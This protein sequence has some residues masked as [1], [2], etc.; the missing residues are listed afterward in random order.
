MAK[1]KPST[2]LC[3]YCKTEI[4]YDAK[5]CPQCRKRVKGG[6]MKW[7]VIAIVVMAIIGIISGGGGKSSSSTNTVTDKTAVTQNVSI[8]QNTSTE[9]PEETKETSSPEKTGINA[10]LDS[11]KIGERNAVLSAINY[12]DF[13]AF[14]RDGLIDQLSSEYGSGYTD[15][16][17]N[18]AVD[19]LEEHSLVDWDEQAIR[20][21]QNYLDFTAFSRQGLINQ[22]SSE[23]GSQFTAEQAT[24][25]V[26]YLEQN[27]LVDWK[28]QAV[29]A[30]K[31]YLEI[32]SFSRSGLID[33]LSSP[34]GSGFTVEEATYAADQLGY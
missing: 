10:L 8:T 17:A 16:E 1:E 18:F 6:A 9:I 4:P 30:A 14:S 33:Q 23:Y 28:E 32:M 34:Y 22:L 11:L 24:K 19:F 25:A 7:I 3:K 12:L 27:N 20:S 2:K 29:K 5:V 13:T 15:E 31:N 26:D 21:A